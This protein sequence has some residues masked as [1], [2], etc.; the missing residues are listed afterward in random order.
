MCNVAFTESMRYP[1]SWRIHLL[2][3][4]WKCSERSFCLQMVLVTSVMRRAVWLVG[5]AL[6]HD[7]P[8][9]PRHSLLLQPLTPRVFCTSDLLRNRT[10]HLH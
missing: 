5:M 3:E 9:R 4:L 10:H 8:S 7:Q 6:A 1:G 2:Y